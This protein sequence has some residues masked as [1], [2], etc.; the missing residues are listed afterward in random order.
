M[1]GYEYLNKR[2]FLAS[3]IQSR[4]NEDSREGVPP[5]AAELSQ[6]QSQDYL[7]ALVATTNKKGCNYYLVFYFFFLR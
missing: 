4:I 5:A 7:T 6:L 2:S 3:I 1:E